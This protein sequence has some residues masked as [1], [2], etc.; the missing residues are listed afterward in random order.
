MILIFGYLQLLH[1]IFLFIT[2]KYS[3]IPQQ[4]LFI[5]FVKMTTFIVAGVINADCGFFKKINRSTGQKMLR[6][7][8][9][10]NYL[11]FFANIRSENSTEFQQF[12]ENYSLG[13]PIA[14]MKT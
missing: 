4:F 14:T 10:C 3:F 5:L 11:Y 6:L 9:V 8:Y 2:L 13:K 7:K 12:T 1:Y